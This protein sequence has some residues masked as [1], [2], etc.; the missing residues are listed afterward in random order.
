MSRIL[1]AFT[2]M[3]TLLGFATQSAIAELRV[4][5]LFRDN[6][7]LQR[8]VKLPVWGTTKSDQPVTV[9]FADRSATATPKDGRWRVEFAPFSANDQ[10]Q[11]L[12]ITQLNNKIEL[13]N[14]L[15][16]DVWICG[17]QSNMYVPLRDSEGSREAIE[18]S[19]NDQLRLFFINPFPADETHPQEP[20]DFVDGN[21]EISGPK[22]SH[23]FT[24]VGYYFGRELQKEVKVPVGLIESC[25]G[26]TSAERWLSREAMESN[27]KL[28]GSTEGRRYELYNGLIAPLKDFP[29]RGFLWYQGESNSPRSWQYRD[30]LP[31]LIKNWRDDWKLG[32]LPFL[33]VQLPGYERIH[34]EPSESDWADMREA[35]LFVSQTV[36]NVGLVVTTDLGDEH[37]VHPRRKKEVGERLALAARAMSY[38]EKIPYS[39]PIYKS[40]K[41]EGNKIVVEFSHIGKGLTGKGGTLTGFTIAGADRKFH[42]AFAKIVGDR[43]EVFAD[44]VPEPVAVRYGWAK[45]PVVN[46]WNKDGLPASPFRTDD[47][48]L[49]TRDNK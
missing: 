40:T 45:Y 4:H 43:V 1:C 21:W 15:I 36:P 5:G 17:G 41:V 11:T 8:D 3:V 28:Q 46:L 2:A 20:L 19:A 30:L 13:K 42:N 14:V 26:G 12:K 49:P 7:V 37:D 27:P 24:A 23:G 32:D 47:F 38:G 10:P 35:Q 25:L 18:K 34:D 48:P 16:G 39:G 22:T 44:E 9:Q 29:V 33:V 31:A 6:A